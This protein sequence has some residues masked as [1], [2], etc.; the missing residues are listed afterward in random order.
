MRAHIAMVSAVALLACG[1]GEQAPSEATSA[2]VD[3]SAMCAEHGVLEALCTICNPALVPVF[4]ARGDYCEEHRLPESICPVCH[5]ERG[6][7]PT[8]A[9]STDQAPADGTRVRLASVELADRI[10]IRVEPATAAPDVI[11][12]VATARVV[13][14]PNRHA[15]LNARSPGVIRTIH[16]D[17][18]AEVEAGDALVT[19]A[20]AGVGA[21]RTRVAAARTRLEVAE[22]ALRRHESLEGII[23]ERQRLETRR[24]RDEARAELAALRASLGVVGANRG[25]E[26]TLRAPIAGVVTARAGSVGAFVETDAVLFEVVDTSKIWVELDIPEDDVA[27]VA[28]GQH[29]IVTTSALGD[30]LFEGTLAY[31]A[32]AIDPHTRTALGRVALDNPDGALRAGMFG[33]ARVQVPRA[34]PALVVPAASVQ[35]ARGAALV[36]VKIAP[37]LYEGRRVEVLER[38][39]DPENLEVRGRISPGDEVVV[40]GAFLLRTETVSDSIGAGCCEGEEVGG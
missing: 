3:P 39:A 10:G 33:R 15:R 24:E 4:R 27:R 5:P 12:V 1:P 25:A 29:V 36:F 7:R 23:S 31:V 30:R 6:G 40:D 22:A 26:Y 38:P 8:D 16:A 13:Y 17:I 35:R 28:T 2:P 32:P 21:D 11:E 20:S 9:V 18:G 19:I 34:E 14:D 37:E